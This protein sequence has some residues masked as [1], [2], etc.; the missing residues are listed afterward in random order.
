MSTRDNKPSDKERLHTVNKHD[1]AG[2]ILFNKYD[3]TNCLAAGVAHEVR[4]VPH[5]ETDRWSDWG[6]GIPTT[7]LECSNCKRWNGPWVSAD[8][9]GGG[10]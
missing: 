3:C 9:V 4:H 1:A 10:W 2:H 8:I 7:R 5:G 6:P